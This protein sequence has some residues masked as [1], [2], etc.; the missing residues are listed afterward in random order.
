MHLLDLV[1]S[2]YYIILLLCFTDT[3]QKQFPSTSPDAIN[4]QITSY[5]RHSKERYSKKQDSE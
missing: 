4:M 5:L 1:F 3:V 2:V